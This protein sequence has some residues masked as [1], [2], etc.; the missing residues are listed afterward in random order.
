MYSINLDVFEDGKIKYGCSIPNMHPADMILRLN[1]VIK[2]LCIVL[3]QA[4]QKPKIDLID[5]AKLPP[6]MKL[7]Q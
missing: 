4:A 7:R 3:L 5:P 6:S 1:E 2:S